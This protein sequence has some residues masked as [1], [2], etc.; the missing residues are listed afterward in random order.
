MTAH[1]YRRPRSDVATP[2]LHDQRSRRVAFVSHCLLNENTRYLGGALQPGAATDVLADL[3]DSR[4]G[5]VQMPCPEQYAWGGVHK[6]LI[7]RG[8]GLRST[9]W[10]R[11][12]QPLLAIVLA[13]TRRAYRRLAGEVVTQIADYQSNGYIV[14][15]LIGVGASPSCGVHTTLDL[16]C[17]LEAMAALDQ[18]TLTAD[19][20]NQDV[21][22]ACRHPGAG[23]FIQAVR[24]ELKRHHLDV[25]FQEYDLVCEMR[26]EPQHFTRPPSIDPGPAR[27]HRT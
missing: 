14:V 15:G 4:I 22:L 10:Y 23:L 8:Y 12:R 6:R 17:A 26:S 9:P 27:D 24:R 13:H 11:L 19:Q 25:P 3:V 2:L 5:I 21:V 16:P 18:A 20:V 1:R 7:M